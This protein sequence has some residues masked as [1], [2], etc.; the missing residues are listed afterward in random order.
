ML[1]R[2]ALYL[3]WLADVRQQ[4]R[5]QT[6][7][8]ALSLLIEACN[9]FQC[10]LRLGLNSDNVADLLIASFSALA[11]VGLDAAA[12]GEAALDAEGHTAFGAALALRAEQV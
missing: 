6:A 2:L 7:S 4:R 12:M 10:M 11:V 5:P 8:A 9:K 1:Q 3:D